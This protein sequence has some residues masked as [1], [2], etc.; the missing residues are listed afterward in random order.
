MCKTEFKKLTSPIF[1]IIMNT[2]FGREFEKK[3][4][5]ILAVYFNN[6]LN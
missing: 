6:M 4:P 1:I 2:Q 3:N 5:K